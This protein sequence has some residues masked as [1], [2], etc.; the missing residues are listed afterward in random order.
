MNT[1]HD[2]HPRTS[3]ALLLSYVLSLPVK[4]ARPG[5]TPL[6]YRQETLRLCETFQFTVGIRRFFQR[7]QH[8]TRSRAQCRLNEVLFLFVAAAELFSRVTKTEP[9]PDVAGR[10]VFVSSSLLFADHS[11]AER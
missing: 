11:E 3:I 8:V 7:S 2:I 6:R 4:I 5:Q 9:V 10:F 1:L